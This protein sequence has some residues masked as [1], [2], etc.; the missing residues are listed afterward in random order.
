MVKKTF[1]VIAALV[2]LIGLKANAGGVPPAQVGI[3]SVGGTAYSGGSINYYFDMN[4]LVSDQLVVKA[5]IKGSG[6]KVKL[7][8]LMGTPGA[9]LSTIAGPFTG[10]PAGFTGNAM[11]TVKVKYAGKSVAS[12]S[13]LVTIGTP[14][15]VA[16]SYSFSVLDVGFNS[17]ATLNG[18]QVP[19]TYMTNGPLT[20]AWTKTSGPSAALSDATVA[21]PT[22]TTGHW[23]NFVT[24]ATA[25]GTLVATNI[26]GSVTNILYPHAENRF[27]KIGTCAL[28]AQEMSASTYKFRVLVSDS[29]ITR[30]GTYTVVCSAPTPAHPNMPVG[31]TAY[32]K[33]RTS[34][35]NWV[36][37]S[38]PV[39]SAALLTHQDDTV[40]Q[41]RPDVEG[42]Y[43]V[44]DQSLPHWITSLTL[45]TNVSVSGTF[46]NTSDPTTTIY[47]KYTTNSASVTNIT[48][49]QW[50]T[51][52]N[53]A[54]SW[55]GVEFCAVC[56]GPGNNVNQKDMVTKWSGTGHAGFFKEMIDGESP[57]SA[58]YGEGCIYCHT[59]GYNKATAANNGGFDDVATLLGWS[60]P[61]SK[62]AGTFDAMPVALKAKANIQCENCHG[63]GSRHPG[64]PSL[65]A[66]VKVC[67]Q[68]HEDG[69]H[70][71]RPQQWDVGPHSGGYESIASSRGSNNTCARCH[72]PVGFTA[73]AKGDVNL[74]DTN[75]IPVGTGPLTCQTC[76]DPHDKFGNEDRHQLRVWD[77]ALMGNP[78][79]RTNTVTVALG[80]STFTM[81]DPRMTNSNLQVT[82]LGSSA[83]CIEC[84]NGRQ[85][86]TQV[87]VYGA[88]TNQNKAFYQ[89]GGPHDQLAGEVFT[90]IGA[91][92]Y[93]QAMGNSFHT[94]LATCQSCHMD[95]L[96]A[97]DTILVNGVKTTNISSYV[98]LV[99]DHTFKMNYVN[100]TNE[101]ENIAA[102]NRCHGSFT[103][104]EEFDFVP[105][106][107]WGDI[108]GNGAV[109]GV[110]TEIRGLLRS[111]GDL[112][113]WGTNATPANG[114]IFTNNVVYAGTNATEGIWMPLRIKRTI[115]SGPK[116]NYITTV[117]TGVGSFVNSFGSAFD[118]YGLGN[119][120]NTVVTEAQRKAVWNWL[121]EYREGSF[122]VHNTQYSIRLL[123]TTYTDLSTN[124]SGN[125]S[126]TFKNVFPSSYLR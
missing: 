116:T 42:V 52:T 28:T 100:G 90:G 13:F 14:P 40:A 118:Y 77:T 95:K 105:D 49:D 103:P 8:E 59:V 114:T 89:V 91:Y 23:T 30:T 51:I 96:V 122:G 60:F 1:I 45:L 110:Q 75:S 115:V 2:A 109:A 81:L 16:D 56:H 71:V 35:T 17:L 85:L 5:S 11:M 107:N 120:N 20:Y 92:D 15:P 74:A 113:V 25:T 69:S 50:N 3:I 63:P 41:L 98:N 9:G 112:I 34:S 26:S 72:S 94:T 123:Q 22:F 106:G 36:M 19:T 7:P 119:T 47:T 101:V 38:Q 54:A 83:A 125:A 102:C 64:S 21:S 78:Y 82:G 39:G 27:G 73:V 37:L 6:W 32:V 76:H 97:G 48:V 53:T 87:Q 55:M 57:S 12:R 31:V 93:G 126:R 88:Y 18:T 33:N 67:A 104:V 46:T 121:T 24:T 10:V 61:S 65:T 124:C 29:S 79:F 58:Y 80:D 117:D 108:D 70:H 44:Q 84:H 62:V 66:D 86:P 43:V 111:L 4:A 99:G 68:C